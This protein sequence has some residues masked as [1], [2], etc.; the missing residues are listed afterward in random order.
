MNIN[1]VMCVVGVF[2]ICGAFYAT[3]IGGAFSRGRYRPISGAGRVI[4]LLSGITIFIS[5]L[6]RLLMR[7][8]L[9]HGWL[10]GAVALSSVVVVVVVLNLRRVRSSMA[11]GTS[12][13]TFSIEYPN[14]L[15][16]ELIAVRI[17]FFVIVAMMLVFGAVPMADS[18]AKTGI[19]CCVLALFGIGFLYGALEHHYLKTGHAAE[20][21][22][23]DENGD[24]SQTSR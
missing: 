11:T 12:Q 3:G 15:P 16:S 23:P 24:E 14:G 19:I 17:A 13:A 4:L 1:I 18:V 6:D 5:G 7:S 22:F 8:G 21:K 20:I 9:L 2:F 10:R